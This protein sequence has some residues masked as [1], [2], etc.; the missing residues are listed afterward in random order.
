MEK[1][2]VVYYSRTGHTRQIAELIARALGGDLEAIIDTKSRDGI[3][4]YFLSAWES[5]QEKLVSIQNPEKNP[6]DYDLVVLG[7]PTWAGK[8]SSPMRTYITNHPKSFSNIALFCTSISPNNETMLQGMASLCGQD[9]IASLIVTESEIKTGTFK[10]T[11]AK[12]TSA[13]K[14][15]LKKG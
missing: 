15:H 1:V 6:V 11:L 10:E 7:S 9:P 3:F 2:L 12:F 4:R 13:L 5:I 8:M 14:T